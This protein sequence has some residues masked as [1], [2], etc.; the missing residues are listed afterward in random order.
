MHR[1]LPDLADRSAPR[2]TS[3]PTAAE[4]HEG[5][6]AADQA[7]ALRSVTP[8]APVAL[9]LHIPFCHEI[10]WYCG[11]NTGALGRGDR[12]AA[13]RDALLREIE[14]VGA[15]M[16]GRVVSVHLGGGSPNVLAAEDLIEISRALRLRFDIAPDADWAVEI[17]PRS[18]DAD[19]A[20]A[21]A[22]A[23]I[24]RASLGAQTFAP[25]VQLRIGRIQPF[26]QVAR[27]AGALR[28]AGIE[29]IS[30]DLMYGLPAQRLDD[31][32]GTIAHA[33]SLR[34]DRIAM[35]GYAHMPH[36]IARQRRI[37][38]HILPDAK[39]RF[40]QSALAHDLF[41]E[42]G[43]E[44]VGFD[45]FARPDD[46]LA[47][48]AR[49]GTL[50]R[51]FQ[52][53]TADRAA[54]VIGLGASSISLFDGLIVQNE[55]HFGRYRMMAG[56][57]MLTGVRGVVRSAE[58]RMRGTVIERLLCDGAVDAAAVAARHGGSTAAFAAGLPLLRRLAAA[59]L[60]T[61]DGWQIRLTPSGR[62]YA[63]VAASAFD[64]YRNGAVHRFSRAV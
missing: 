18:M 47:V 10:C 5:V 14:T 60:L 29:R 61:L 9:Y 48:A 17:D 50:R 59:Q 30:L 8:D 45:H 43:F 4:F 19:R 33:L 21:L 35:F 64:G 57:G 20:V 51:N 16:R 62:A 2:Y 52:G 28:A 7:Q 3:Y 63:R 49:D 39:A 23:G 54:T 22:A 36:R 56:N 38:P 34:P 40:W 41:V 26:R 53:F 32:A 42:A 13:Y 46:P 31:I 58:D 55:K 6:G 37:D 1:F 27:V 11:C 12:L 24:N 15:Q 44:P 25:H